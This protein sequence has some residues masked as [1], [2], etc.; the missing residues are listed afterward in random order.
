MER[1]AWIG[2]GK[3]LRTQARTR[4]TRMITRRQN[5]YTTCRTSH[6]LALRPPCAQS[7]PRLLRSPRKGPTRPTNR[8][9]PERDA[10]PSS[11][12]P[13]HAPPGR[14]PL[15]PLVWGRGFLPPWCVAGCGHPVVGLA[16]PHHLSLPH[17]PGTP[18]WHTRARD[19]RAG[20]GGDMSGRLAPDMSQG[21]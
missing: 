9:S 12:T 17:N 15:P 18:C 20:V 19:G 4:N 7:S 5:R 16:L 1:G 11:H 3:R 10:A 6:C 14:P 8:V 13:S 21:Y 2:S